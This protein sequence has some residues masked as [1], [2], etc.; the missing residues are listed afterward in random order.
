MTSLRPCRVAGGGVSKGP[1]VSK[2]G[3]LPA[4][5]VPEVADLASVC[6]AANTIEHPPVRAPFYERRTPEG[7]LDHPYIV[8]IACSGGGEVFSRLHC[9]L[10]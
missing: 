5:Q 4:I 6:P 9:L 1:S 7:R 3:P 10:P 8:V 2:E